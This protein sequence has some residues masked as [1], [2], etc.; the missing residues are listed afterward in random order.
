MKTLRPLCFTSIVGIILL[1]GARLYAED[2]GSLQDSINATRNS[3]NTTA[4]LTLGS[5]AVG[6]M[7]VNG[8]LLALQ[9]NRTPTERN[10][11]YYFQQMNIF[12][13]V[14]NLGLAAGGLYGSLTEAAHPVSLFETIEKQASI[15]RILLLNA[16]LD[17]AYIAAGAWMLERSKTTPDQSA[18]W[19]GYGQSLI[20]QGA[21]LLVFD[22][23]VYAIQ[24]GS[25]E[26]LLREILNSIRLGILPASGVSMGLC[27]RL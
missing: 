13:N 21:F 10:S 17:I 12:W 24:H 11:A 18:L 8:T 9:S 26:P 16:G 4:M 2:T 15:E 6:N 25:S 14:I 23:A 19:Q 7:A 3:I 5:W 27:L 20:V 1:L 22:V